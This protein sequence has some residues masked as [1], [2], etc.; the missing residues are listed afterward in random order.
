MHQQKHAHLLVPPWT[1]ISQERIPAIV[2]VVSVVRHAR[3]Y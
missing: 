3:S 2:G 1:V